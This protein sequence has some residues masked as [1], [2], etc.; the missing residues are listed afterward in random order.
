MCT[1]NYVTHVIS[2]QG[3]ERVKCVNDY[4]MGIADTEEDIS[5]NPAPNPD[6][7]LVITCDTGCQTPK[8][9]LTSPI[10]KE[11]KEEERSRAEPRKRTLEPGTTAAIAVCDLS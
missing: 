8:E 10:V 5:P 2:K 4:M 6:C 7:N 1:M 11:H 3:W 9:W